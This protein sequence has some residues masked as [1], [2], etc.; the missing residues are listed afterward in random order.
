MTESVRTP[1]PSAPRTAPESAPLPSVIHGG[2]AP[3]APGTGE[4]PL[5]WYESW[6][7]STPQALA[8][9][10]GEHSWSYAEL[11]AAATAVADALRDRVAPGDLVGVLLDRSAALVAVAIGLARIG[12]VYLPLGPRPGE[13]RLA[14]ATRGLRVT[15]LIG[16]PELLP[17]EHRD[18]EQRALPVPAEGANAA[19]TAVAAFTTPA[20]EARTAPAG[21]WYAVLTSGSTGT[22]KAVAVGERSLGT[23]L[24]WHRAR[25]A[26][27]QD[28]RHSL[29]IGVA[30][31]PHV[32]ELWA[33]LSCGASLQVAPDAVRW[34]PSALT[35]WWRDAG[36]TVCVS[37]TPMLEPLL[38]RPWPTGLALRH[39][40]VGGDR[41]RRRPGPDVT[42]VV[43]NAYGPAEATVVSSAYA[44]HGAEPSELDGAPPIGHPVAGAT[45]CVTDAEGHT[46]PRGEPGELR[47][48]GTCLALGYLDPE[49]TAERFAHH[50]EHG[51]LYRTGDRAL[52]RADGQLEFLGRLDDQV[53]VGGVRIEPAEVEAAFEHDPRVRRAVVAARSTVQGVTQLLAFVLPAPGAAPTGPDLLPGVRDW[54]PQQA[55]PAVVRVVEGY[56]LDA[57]GKVDRPALLAAESAPPAP[58]AGDA[59]GTENAENTGNADDPAGAEEA[60]GSASEQLVLRLCRDLL[61]LPRLG[62]DAHFTESGGTSL[63]AARLLA[64][65]QDSCGV[66]LRAPELLRQPDLRGIAALMDKR[67]AAYGS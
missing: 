13:R 32:L 50:P 57:N 65:L 45:L 43:H 53:K 12:A 8:V 49:L 1:L 27:T 26:L 5:A 42:A 18:A 24:R 21:T 39:V 35:D 19:A 67:L 33:A 47:I 37:A 20:P 66:R 63:A 34:D 2:P 64:A 31:D 30:F 52:M 29:L 4:T 55:V 58:A 22:P 41:L 28:D 7:R 59:Q 51:R 17:D 48:G 25:T 44:M 60:A 38:D 9:G 40:Y 36:V 23:L 61:G 16:D 15:C 62:L 46:V 11:D 14:A 54:L 56:P 6:V 10:D 3:E